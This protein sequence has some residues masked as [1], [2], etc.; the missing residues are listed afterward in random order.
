MLLKTLVTVGIIPKEK[1]EKSHRHSLK[2]LRCKLQISETYLKKATPEQEVKNCDSRPACDRLT[3][4]RVPSGSINFISD[5]EK[6]SPEARQLA[7]ELAAQAA[8][9]HQHT[10]L[11]VL[12]MGGSDWYPALVLVPATPPDREERG[13]CTKFTGV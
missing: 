10:P 6:H 8:A 11:P 13:H 1:G 7:Q 5:Y 12:G 3:C 2:Q 4:S 9:P